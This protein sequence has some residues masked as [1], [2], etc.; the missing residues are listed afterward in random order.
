MGR[1]MTIAGSPV[2]LHSSLAA[3]VLPVPF[4]PLNITPRFLPLAANCGDVHALMVLF[5]MSSQPRSYT[6]KLKVNES[7]IFS[8]PSRWLRAS[9]CMRNTPRSGHGSSVA[10]PGMG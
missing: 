5:M 9:S 2:R 4:S 7:P 8:S 3:M 10:L 6:L 1:D